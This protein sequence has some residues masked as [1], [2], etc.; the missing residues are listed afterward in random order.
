MTSLMSIDKDQSHSHQLPSSIEPRL[1][2]GM[3]Y[4]ADAVNVRSHLYATFL[5]SGGLLE[6]GYFSVNKTFGYYC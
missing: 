2:V 5:H 6:T 4:D 3:F 1:V